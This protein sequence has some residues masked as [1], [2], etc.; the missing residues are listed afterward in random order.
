MGEIG[1]RGDN[2]L[3]E[4]GRVKILGRVVATTTLGPDHL[5]AAR[6]GVVAVAAVGD[7][8]QL[9]I[10]VANLEEAA[11]GHA[12]RQVSRIGAAQHL[13]AFAGGFHPH[14][15]AKFDVRA[16]LVGDATG[17]LGRQDERNALSAANAGDAFELSLILSPVGD[18]LG[19][20]VNDDKEEGIGRDG[21]VVAFASVLD[22]VFGARLDIQALAALHLRR[23]RREHAR[24]AIGGKIGEDV[25]AVRQ[26]GKLAEGTAAL[27]V[28][29]HK[30]ERRR[31]VADRHAANQRDE[32]FG[33]ARAGAAGDHPVNAVALGRKDELAN[34]VARHKAQLHPEP[35]GLLI[36]LFART[37]ALMGRAPQVNQRLEAF[38][39]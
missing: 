34:L 14:T 22:N 32:Q 35:I 3:V 37:P 38:E 21:A 4:F 1:Q 26:L 23:N 31:A 20:L 33:F 15:D 39:R 36:F 18:H 30:V 7:L 6:G 8:G 27:V 25:N 17:P 2:R 24:H 29:Q 28:H 10:L 16:H 5:G 19:E 13:A 12:W 9:N 11:T